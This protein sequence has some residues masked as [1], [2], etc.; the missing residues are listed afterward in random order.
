MH[1]EILVLDDEGRRHYEIS[2]ERVPAY[3]RK[4]GRRSLLAPHQL[5][6]RHS[7]G[8]SQVEA[9]R[10]PHSQEAA[11]QEVAYAGAGAYRAR[12]LLLQQGAHQGDREAQEAHEHHNPEPRQLLRRPEPAAFARSTAAESTS[13]AT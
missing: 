5:R 4:A 8:E 3:E 12:A 9:H 11:L 1:Y 6:A 2:L 7:G 13:K 10:A